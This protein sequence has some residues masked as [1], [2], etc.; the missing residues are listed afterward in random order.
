METVIKLPANF[1]EELKHLKHYISKRDT[2]KNITGFSVYVKD[3]IIYMAATDSYKAIMI[4][5]GLI[6]STR[7]LEDTQERAV[8]DVKFLDLMIKLVKRRSFNVI[9]HNTI[10][11]SF[12]FQDPD[13]KA[14]YTASPITTNFPDVNKL[15]KTDISHKI[16]T[17]WVTS[18]GFEYRKINHSMFTTFT[19]NNRR[20]LYFDP[21]M[22]DLVINHFKALDND[23]VSI[24]YQGVDASLAYPIYLEFNTGTMTRIILLSQK[25]V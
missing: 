23:K 12:S 3:N 6:E 17:S 11:R 16:N 14:I 7:K 22:T 20:K 8:Y 21:K 9:Y 2:R 19:M 18:F 5:L 13:S 25:V 4:E 15:F 24:Y 1:V 10:D